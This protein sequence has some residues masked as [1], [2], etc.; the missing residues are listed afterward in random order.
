[1][2]RRVTW[3]LTSPILER[4]RCSPAIA[5][6]RFLILASAVAAVDHVVRGIFMPY[7]I[8]GMHHVELWRIAE[9]ALW[10]VWEDIFLFRTCFQGVLQLRHM[11]AQSAQ[12]KLAAE[13][14]AAQVSTLLSAA[15]TLNEVSSLLG[16]STQQ[17]MSEAGSSLAQARTVSE[18]MVHVSEQVAEMDA[19][20]KTISASVSESSDRLSHSDAA[21]V[22]AVQE[23]AKLIQ[24][25]SPD[26]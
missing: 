24:V 9:H 4:W 8:F 26:Q 15:H 21:A 10:V 12:Q 22:E 7:S 6:W 19:S 3:R 13:T 1:M 5:K 25:E 2:S 16:D 14:S 18:Q 23:V 11:A 17:L 20:V